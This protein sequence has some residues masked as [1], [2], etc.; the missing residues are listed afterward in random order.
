MQKEGQENDQL[1]TVRTGRSKQEE[2]VV[3]HRA[4][5]IISTTEIDYR[6]SEAPIS[7]MPLLGDPLFNAVAASNQ[8]KWERNVGGPTTDC[9]N[10]M[11]PQ[12]RNQDISITLS[13]GYRK[14]LEVIDKFKLAPT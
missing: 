12:D 9:M 8:W 4:L 14:G 3:I 10:A 13:L 2:A 5:V 11:V 7:L 1:Q 6:C